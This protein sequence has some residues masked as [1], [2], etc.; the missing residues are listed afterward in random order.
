MKNILFGFQIPGISLIQNTQHFY[1][2]ATLRLAD[3]FMFNFCIRIIL[4]FVVF[5]SKIPITS[6]H[7]LI[8]T[9]KHDMLFTGQNSFYVQIA[10][11]QNELAHPKKHWCDT[12]P[13]IGWK[14]N[15]ISFFCLLSS[16]RMTWM[17]I[18]QIF[19][20]MLNGNY[21]HY[22]LYNSRSWYTPWL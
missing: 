5:S 3:R 9:H 18:S 15:G 7:N 1:V 17:K 13:S 12:K 10:V 19:C 20:H 22:Y 14:C 2:W 4:L 16:Y 8:L 21:A 6:V 11:R